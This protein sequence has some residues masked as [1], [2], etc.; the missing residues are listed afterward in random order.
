M[1]DEK[2]EWYGDCYGRTPASDV[3]WSMAAP[4]WG[5]CYW[6]AWH[7][8]TP[9]GEFSWQE[10]RPAFLR[11]VVGRGWTQHLSST[12]S[13]VM[14]YGVTPDSPIEEVAALGERLAVEDQE[15]TRKFWSKFIDGKDRAEYARI[16]GMHYALGTRKVPGQHNGMG[17]RWHTIEFNDGRSVRSCDLWYQGKIPPALL[18]QLPDNAKFAA[19]AA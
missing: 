7:A 18:A 6:I 10:A 4:E 9:A 1:S 8:A 19:S 15:K 12:R 14:D 17:G 3:L 16:G 2:P 5:V 13:L 11:F